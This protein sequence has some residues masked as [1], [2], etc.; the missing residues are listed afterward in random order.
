MGTIKDSDND[1]RRQIKRVLNQLAFGEM[2]TAVQQCDEM[3][4][5]KA[6]EAIKAPV[7]KLAKAQE[8][9]IEVLRKVLDA[10]RH[11]EKDALAEM[12]KRPGGELPDDTKKKLEEA[13][14]RLDELTKRQK[15][16]LEATENLAKKPTEDFAEGEQEQLIKQ[17]KALED[18]WGK[19]QKD[20]HSD[21]S[22]L[23]EQDFANGSMAKEMSEIQTEPQDGRRRH[24]EESRPDRRSPGA[25]GVRAG[26]V[27]QYEHREV[28]P[29]HAETRQV[30]PGR[31]PH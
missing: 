23:P 21:L 6:A 11:A 30:E 16:I 17:M 27:A 26:G 3:V 8:R 15:K 14:R 13:K 25:I 31:G 5:Q 28:A 19:F 1:D 10:T 9:V 20:L 12:K 2:L 24:V 18:D 4:K 29:R 7:P 22:K